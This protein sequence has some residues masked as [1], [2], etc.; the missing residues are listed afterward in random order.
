MNS[1]RL[2]IANFSEVTSSSNYKP[3]RAGIIPYFYDNKEFQYYFVI[4]RDT[5]SGELTDFGGGVKKSQELYTNTACREFV[6]ESKGCFSLLEESDIKDE[7]LCVFDRNNLI[8][9][10][11]YGNRYD[12]EGMDNFEIIDEN[13]SQKDV[14]NPEISEL[15]ILRQ[16]RFVATVDEKIDNHIFYHVPGN[17]LKIAIKDGLLEKL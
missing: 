7:T 11:Y 8:I 12:S 14:D 1:G 2:S 10:V 15:I 4:G 9:F 13:F 17:L 5:N 16:D 6:E 3:R